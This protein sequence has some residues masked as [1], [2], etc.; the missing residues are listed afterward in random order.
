MTR[1]LNQFINSK[2]KFSLFRFNGMI[3][4]T[5]V[6]LRDQNGPRGGLDKFCLL[7]IELDGG[8]PDL[9]VKDLQKD[10]YL[11]IGKAIARAK[12]ALSRE[13]HKVHGMKK[14]ALKFNQTPSVE[15]IEQ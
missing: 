1:A 9:I 13:I 4:S 2:I 8:M 5:T 12:Y 7:K 15:L 3:R 14:R 10:P 11:A 6:S